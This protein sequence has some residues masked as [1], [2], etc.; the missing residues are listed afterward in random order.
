MTRQWRIQGGGRGGA[1]EPPFGLHLTLRSTDDRLNG[2]PFLAIE[3]RKLLLWLTLECFRRKFVRKRIDC[4]GRACRAGSWFQ[5]RSKMGVVP[6]KWAWLQKLSG[7]KLDKNDSQ[8]MSSSLLLMLLNDRL[9]SGCWSTG[10]LPCWLGGGARA[11]GTPH[12]PPPPGFLRLCLVGDILRMTIG[13]AR[14]SHG[15]LYV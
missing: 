8:K 15:P 4:T 12:P 2:T 6:P 9:R 7:L 10:P 14:D 13:K 5:K 1:N 3:L 11:P